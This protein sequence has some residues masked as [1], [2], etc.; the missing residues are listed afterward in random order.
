[1]LTAPR[2]VDAQSVGGRVVEEGTLEPVPYAGVTLVDSADAVIASTVADSLGSFFVRA[3]PGHYRLRADR[4]GFATATS[5]SIE[6]R[7]NEPLIVELRLSARGVP[8][9]PLIVRA[10]GIDR[11]EDAFKRRREL[12]EGVFLTQDSIALRKPRFAWDVFRGVAGI[13]VDQSGRVFSFSGGRC[14][15]IYVDNNARPYAWYN[16]N[17]SRSGLFNSRRS[18]TAGD[19]RLALGGEGYG[20]VLGGNLRGI[21]V[22]R[23]FWEIPEELRTAARVEALWPAD[24]LL[25]CG[26]ALIWTKVAW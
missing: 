24:V 5:E 15:A 2:A 23:D 11:G 6:L 10:R 9:E 13:N 19:P 17:R 14:M 26:M 8:L 1:M 16:P 4:I 20:H 3:R 18:A 22:Y 25:P 21:E 12:G 7:E